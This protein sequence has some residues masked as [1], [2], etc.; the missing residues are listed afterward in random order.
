MRL[1]SHNVFLQFIVEFPERRCIFARYAS[2]SRINYLI[3]NWIS[4]KSNRTSIPMWGMVM[5]HFSVFLLYETRSPPLPFITEL[6]NTSNVASLSRY[7]L[8][9]LEEEIFICSLRCDYALSHSRLL[10]R[11]TC[12]FPLSKIQ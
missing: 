12:R 5:E 3:F 4:V 8:S 1:L 6:I 7:R 2:Q 10:P 9:Y 11:F